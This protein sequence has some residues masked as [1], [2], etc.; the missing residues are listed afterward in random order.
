LRDL[1]KI[2]VR[3]ETFWILIAGA[4]ILP[5]YVIVNV[6][7]VNFSLMIYFVVLTFIGIGAVGVSLWYSIPKFLFWL[8]VMRYW[9]KLDR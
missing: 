4:F 1:R 2:N 9:G 3:N 7:P 6:I 8:K 5:I